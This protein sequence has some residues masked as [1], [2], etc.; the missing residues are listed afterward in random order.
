MLQ[1]SHII[2]QPEN[3]GTAHGILL[4]VLWVLQRDPGA[5][6]IFFPADHYVQDEPLLARSLRQAVSILERNPSELLLV[7]I[8][9]ETPDSELGYIVPGIR[10]VDG[11]SGVAEFVEK[12]DMTLASKMVDKGAL[13]N[14]F[15]FG[16]GGTG[17][18]RLLR[19]RMPET[20]TVM[21]AAL[22]IDRLNRIDPGL[23]A[24]LYERLASVDFSRAILQGNESSLGV[25]K[26]PA[27]G[28]TDLGT[29]GRVADTL[30]RLSPERQRRVPAAAGHISFMNL[31]TRHAQL[32][33]AG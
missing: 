6:I 30:R 14:S 22:R 7:G 20:V 5:R 28:W 17:L 4:A 18:L 1:A 13:W 3:R 31:A 12:P 19:E 15:I 27:C 33:A 29:P 2:E 8:E 23:L 24:M 21:R 26:A 25:L 11:S 10:R 9:P 16:A 32:Q